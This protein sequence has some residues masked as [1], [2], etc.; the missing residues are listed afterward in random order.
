MANSKVVFMAS[1]IFVAIMIFNGTF[2]ALGRPLKK[3]Q[4]TT[5]ENSIEEIPTVAENL[6]MWRR[7]TLEFKEAATAFDI[8]YQQYDRVRKW[9]DDFRPTD[10]GHSPGAGH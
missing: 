10:P 8:K 4:A 3:E 7:D 2:S 1:S 9:T 6:V 5:Y